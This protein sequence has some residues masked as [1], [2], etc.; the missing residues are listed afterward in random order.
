MPLVKKKLKIKKINNE[1]KLVCTCDLV[2][3]DSYFTRHIKDTNSKGKNASSQ[4]TTIS[5][6][7]FLIT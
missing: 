3:L 4:L 2:C 7:V 1:R 5:T 6:Y